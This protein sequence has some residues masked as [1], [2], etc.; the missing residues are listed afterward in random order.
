MR[1]ARRWVKQWEV[2]W[3]CF[4]VMIGWLRG[5]GAGA[6]FPAIT[7]ASVI[8]GEPVARLFDA[9]RGRVFEHEDHGVINLV[10]WR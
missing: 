6:H 4:L 5:C 2:P 9:G 10:K 1:W 8:P 3:L 7:N